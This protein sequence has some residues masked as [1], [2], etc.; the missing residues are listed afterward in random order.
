M[1]MINVD[2]FRELTIKFPE[3]LKLLKKHV[4]KYKDPRINFLKGLIN[5]IYYFNGLQKE[6]VYEILFNFNTE[7]LWEGQ[8][9]LIANDWNIADKLIIVERGEIE[10]YT[11]F[12]GNEFVID[13]LYSGSIIN[14]RS[15]LMQDRV[16]INMRC[17]K[18]TIIQE[19]S[20]DTLKKLMLEFP[21]MQRIVDKNI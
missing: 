14:Y 20:Q 16:Q 9:V 5:K 4:Y 8:H 11:F 15:F 7:L 3:Y 6:E 10:V 21:N 12:E 17:T 1:A 19:L 2:R 18:Q 13:Y